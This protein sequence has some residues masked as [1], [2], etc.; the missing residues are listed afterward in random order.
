[1]GHR[2]LKSY[3][4]STVCGLLLSISIAS[5]GLAAEVKPL[6]VPKGAKCPVCGMFVE[7]YK[8]WSA[9]VVFTDGASAF[10]DGPKDMFRYYFNVS[11]FD[12]SRKQADISAIFVTEYYSTKPLDARKAWFVT[13]SDVFGPMGSELVP[14]D[15][16]AHAREF[17]KDHAGKK[18]LRFGDVGIE[19][20]R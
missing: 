20:V 15:S 14:L 18:V 9:H 12:R 17:M 6:P 11:R 2:A 5:T 16:E 10:F 7:K 3:L 8:E 13:G 19:D 1:M 4:L